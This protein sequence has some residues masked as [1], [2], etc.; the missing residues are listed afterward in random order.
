MYRGSIISILLAACICLSVPLMACPDKVYLGL[1]ADGNHS[2]CDA[3]VVAYSPITLWVWVLPSMQ[4]V[5]CLEFRL[6]KPAWLELVSTTPHFLCADMEEDYD[7]FGEGGRICYE[8]CRFQWTWVFQFTLM[9][10]TD[11]ET[12]FITMAEW[13]RSGE[14]KVSTCKEDRPVQA[15]TPLTWLAIN[16][17]CEVSTET[18][19][20]GAIKSLYR[21]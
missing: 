9:P 10:T 2:D 6:V 3:D 18:E 19:T 7:W 12:G 15:L 13:L 5:E 11:R 14:L 1:Y 21:Q 8:Y 17:P 4:G 20:W 16:Q